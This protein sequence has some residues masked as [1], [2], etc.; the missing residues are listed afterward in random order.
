[1]GQTQSSSIDQ[2]ILTQVRESAKTICQVEYD[3]SIKDVTIIAVGG[4]GDITLENQLKIEGTKCNLSAS[5]NSQIANELSALLDQKSTSITGL[6]PDITSKKQTLAIG[7]SVKNSAALSSYAACQTGANQ[8][9]SNVYIFAED[10][11]RNIHL[12]N[13]GGINNSSCNITNALKQITKNSVKATGK[14][15]MT[16]I[17]GIVLIIVAVAIVALVIFLGGKKGSGSGSGSGGPTTNNL[18]GIDMA[19]MAAMA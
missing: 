14:Q 1:M 18:S 17:S 3:E 4:S 12:I 11:D 10:T 7:Q 5:L 15:S 9:I 19:K 2:A 6:L 8:E 13:N 16:T